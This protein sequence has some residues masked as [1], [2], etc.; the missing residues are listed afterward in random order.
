MKDS[1][2]ELKLPGFEN[3]TLTCKHCGKTIT[4]AR[5][6]GKIG[7]DE[8]PEVKGWCR[9]QLAEDAKYRCEWWCCVA[10]LK[11]WLA[12]QFTP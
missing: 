1:V 5:E 6:R 10:H 4:V 8:H 3:V 9:F 2:V 11:E 12:K 7:W